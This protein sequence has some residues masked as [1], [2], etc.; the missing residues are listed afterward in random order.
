ML[1]ERHWKGLEKPTSARPVL[2]GIWGLF[3]VVSW[4]LLVVVGLGLV[5][6]GFF[7][8]L[9]QP[10]CPE[11][12]ESLTFF[13]PEMCNMQGQISFTSNRA[14]IWTWFSCNLLFLNIL[15]GLSLF[16]QKFYSRTINGQ[17]NGCKK[18]VFLQK[19]NLCLYFP[20]PLTRRIRDNKSLS[21]WR[22]DSDVLTLFSQYCL[23]KKK[24][25][26]WIKD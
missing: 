16:D 18:G 17:K 24:V 13:L 6:V 3:C 2:G 20:L 14:C 26:R 10:R 1:G 25:K 5:L 21:I 11:D 8:S 4:V 22:P 19:E 12:S 23:I 15:G 9:S 7:F